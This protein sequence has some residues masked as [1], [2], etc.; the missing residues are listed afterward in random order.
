VQNLYEPLEKC[1]DELLLFMHHV[2]YTH[3]LHSGKTVIQQIYDSHYA[4]AEEA[5]TLVTEWQSLRG[6]LDDARY[7]EVLNRQQY[8][9]GHAI[10]WRDA[11]V[12]WF[13]KTSGIPDAQGRV[14]HNPNR[15]EPEDMQL[16]GF[17]SVD[18]TPW[19]TASG[20]KAVACARAQV[21]SMTYSFPRE[22]GEYGVA[23]Q[24]FDQNN[25]ASRYQLFVNDRLLDSWTADDHLPS[26]KMNGHTSTRHTLN[27]VALHSGDVFKIVVHPDGGEPAPLDYI[28][29][30][31]ER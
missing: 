21:C 25:G 11:V 18:V 4:G 6:L 2:P 23:I 20:G 22:P 14:G 17:A 12:N 9:A 27:K 7:S 1:P 19:E 5:A 3:V 29:F 28:E 31:S 16:S 24:Y 30:V 15:V 13:A 10:V 8:Q 26:D